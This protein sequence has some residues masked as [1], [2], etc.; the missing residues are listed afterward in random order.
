MKI[1]DLYLWIKDDTLV[2]DVCYVYDDCILDSC[3][4]LRGGPTIKVYGR[5]ILIVKTTSQ[6]MAVPSPM[7]WAMVDGFY[8]RLYNSDIRFLRLISST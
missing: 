8:I 3:H 5:I 1:G 2:S 7:F 4:I 6:P